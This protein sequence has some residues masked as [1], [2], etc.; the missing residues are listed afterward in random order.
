MSDAAWTSREEDII[1]KQREAASHLF[2]YLSGRGYFNPNTPP[3][4][5]RADVAA[6]VSRFLDSQYPL[7]S[8][9]IGW[10]DWH[11]ARFKVVDGVVWCRP[12]PTHGWFSDTFNRYEDEFQK[13]PQLLRLLA[14]LLE[15]PS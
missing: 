11:G 10:P 15:R 2:N 14:D 1:R 7:P 9:E 8:R 3:V 6:E 4:Y 12:T 5:G 13:H